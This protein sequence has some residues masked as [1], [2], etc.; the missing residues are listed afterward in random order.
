MND[1]ALGALLVSF[2]IAG[3]AIIGLHEESALW[4]DSYDNLL[5][6]YG[7][8]ETELDHLKSLKYINLITENENRLE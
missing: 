7:K 3:W 8:M 6:K 5:M 1:I 4:R 2:Y